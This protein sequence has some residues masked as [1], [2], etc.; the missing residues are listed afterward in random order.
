MAQ[1]E[2][3]WAL[4]GAAFVGPREMGAAGHHHRRK[5][6]CPFRGGGD[7]HGGADEDERPPDC[8]DPMNVEFHSDH[9][10]APYGAALVGLGNGDRGA[11]DEDSIHGAECFHAHMEL[12]VAPMKGLRGEDIG[13][14][15]SLLHEHEA[16]AFRTCVIR[17]DRVKAVDKNPV[18]VSRLTQF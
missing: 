17:D 3:G 6:S 16:A 1:K 7:T 8:F 12:A 10:P 18:A 13:V 2:T 11:M 15:R 5:R 9:L 4:L 14:G